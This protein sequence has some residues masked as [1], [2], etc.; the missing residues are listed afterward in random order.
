ML[1]SICCVH[2]LGQLLLPLAWRPLVLCSRC[3]CRLLRCCHAIVHLI[4]ATGTTALPPEAGRAASACADTTGVMALTD[5]RA[6]ARLVAVLQGYCHFVDQRTSCSVLQRREFG[7]PAKAKT[8]SPAAS[9]AI[10]C[11]ICARCRASPRV[12]GMLL[13]RTSAA[14]GAAP[15]LPSLLLLT[16]SAPIPW[17]VQGWPQIRVCI[18]DAAV[19]VPRRKGRLDGRVVKVS[20]SAVQL[21]S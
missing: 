4:P 8:S 2:L 13:A 9:C 18:H 14:A 15:P 16:T 5:M 20:V 17:R 19:K 21:T 3:S 10:C 7:R 11:S 1:L 6:H 12:L